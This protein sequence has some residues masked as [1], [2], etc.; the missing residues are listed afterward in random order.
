MRG[1]SSLC[2]ANDPLVTVDADDETHGEALPHK[3]SGQPTEHVELW[4]HSSGGKL[5]GDGELQTHAPN[6][7]PQQ[8][9]L[10][11]ADMHHTAM[12]D[13]GITATSHGSGAERTV[14]HEYHATMSWDESPTPGLRAGF[15]QMGQPTAKGK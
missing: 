12:D 4:P 3:S 10:V 1:E 9:P 11:F 13:A 5:T 15:P 8:T 6:N 2:E 14:Q 7:D